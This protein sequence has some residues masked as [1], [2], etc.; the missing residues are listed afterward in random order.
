MR[1]EWVHPS[2]RDLVID[3]LADNSAARAQFLSAC[4]A[5]GA[6]LA[7][8]SGGGD[9]GDRELP[10]LTSDP[11]WDALTD[12][13]YQLAPEL[14]TPELFAVLDSIRDA[15]TMLDSGGPRL[16]AEALARTVLSRLTMLWDAV[17]VPIELPAIEAWLALAAELPRDPAPPEPPDLIRNWVQLLPVSA[18]DLDDRES[19]ERFA[20]WLT[21]TDLL[22]E[23]MPDQL[24][25]F[26]FRNHALILN[27][28]LDKIDDAHGRFQ[29]ACRDHIERSLKRIETL[30]PELAGLSRYIAKRLGA[31]Q[32]RLQ[33]DRPH[34][35]TDPNIGEIPGWTL[36]DV[37]RV[38][39]DL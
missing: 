2:W 38:L 15:I 28:F 1:V 27:V 36:F 34:R 25:R 9:Q 19:V 33:R 35:K 30:T 11:D 12:R 13:I 37:E 39:R 14:D 6:L 17:E 3:H 18:P 22:R 4:A 16:E 21:L 29:P 26:H 24:H 5:H 23:H 7:L 8:S 32:T 10:L 31:S 20:D